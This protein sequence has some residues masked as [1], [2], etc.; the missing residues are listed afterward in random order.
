MEIKQSPNKF[1]NQREKQVD[2]TKLNYILA[3]NTLN[4]LLQ[5][6]FSNYIP[7]LMQFQNGN[8]DEFILEI[9]YAINYKECENSRFILENLDNIIVNDKKFEVIQKSFLILWKN[10]K[11]L[12]F[13]ANRFY[14]KRVDG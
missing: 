3:N 1:A 13:I 12:L 14:R 8:M 11:F 2:I 6:Y 9:F 4:Q 7:E 5:F 10:H